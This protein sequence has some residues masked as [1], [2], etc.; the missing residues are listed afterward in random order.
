MSIPSAIAPLEPVS[1]GSADQKITEIEFGILKQCRDL[2]N[3]QSTEDKQNYEQAIKRLTDIYKPIFL[4]SAV[5]MKVHESDIEDVIQDI[6]VKIIHKA[7]DIN[8]YASSHSWFMKVA[9]NCIN[10][11]H[12]KK[13]KKHISLENVD[14]EQLA[15]W[16]HDNALF[17]AVESLLDS[18]EIRI[19]WL[20][21]FENYSAAEVA[22]LL[23]VEPKLTKNA[24]HQRL[25]RI[26]AKLLDPLRTAYPD[27]GGR[28]GVKDRP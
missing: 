24:V 17:Q 19:L 28:G 9:I 18:I 23:A 11:Y 14:E 12:G 6:F 4:K 21:Y 16:P 15:S 8:S 7:K 5:W 26:R 22:D 20:F 2:V 3:L 25:T 10:T 13:S 1:K 27:F